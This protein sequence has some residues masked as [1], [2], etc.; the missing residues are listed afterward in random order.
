MES[1]GAQA[2]TVYEPSMNDPR[3]LAA[4]DTRKSLGAAILAGD[5]K[6][7]EGIFAPDLVVHSPINMV[8]DRENVL[9]RLR[10]GQISY[11]PD[12]EEKI[13]FAAVRGEAVVLM[14]EEIVHPIGKAPNVGKTVH[15]RFTDIWRNFGGVWK[16]AIRQATVTS[17]H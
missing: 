8:V 14:G 15:R 13:E 16:L 6:T 5:F 3:I 11:E 2:R 9:A 10:S 7:V 17:A 4:L 1:A 12:V